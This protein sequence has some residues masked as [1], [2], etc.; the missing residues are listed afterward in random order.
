MVENLSVPSDRRVW[1]ESLTLRDAGYDVSVICPQGTERDAESHVV[2]EGIEVHR[3]PLRSG[4]GYLRE[5]STAL[6]RSLRLALRLGRF[7]VVHIC[8]PPDLLFL[9][10][11]PLK[12]RGARLIFDQHDLVPELYLSRFGRRKDA[13]YRALVLLEKLTYR[14]ADVVVATNESYRAVA[15]GRGGRD[16]SSVYVVRSAPELSRFRNGTAE[17]TLKRGKPHLLCYLGVMGPQD[18]VDYAL[19]ALGALRDVHGRDDW[20]AVFMGAGDSYEEMVRLS[21]SLSLEDSVTFT[22][23]APDAQLL[24]CLAT[25]DVAL[26]PDPLSPF[27]D[28]STMNK[29]LEY[30]AVGRPVVAFDLKEGRVSAAEA[31]VYARPNDVVEFAAR[32]AELLDDPSARARRGEIGRARVANSLGWAHSST[33]LLASY[34]HALGR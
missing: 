20:H 25:A 33:A 23:W 14:L 18:G 16:P 21:R 34:E 30:M 12:L 7:D 26:A 22:G 28:L 11:L 31:A 24:R 8:N 27:N 4:S 9:V 17:P 29:V 10:A 2:L 32:I 1:Q 3:Y 13:V 6:W 15:L 19:R 5:Y